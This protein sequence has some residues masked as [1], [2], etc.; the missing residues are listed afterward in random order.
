MPVK[1]KRHINH[2][3][4]FIGFTRTDSLEVHMRLHENK[5]PILPTLETLDNI[6]EHYIEVD[7]YSGRSESEHSDN[8]GFSDQDDGLP[9]LEEETPG[10]DCFEPQVDIVES[11]QEQSERE[12]TP[13]IK[14]EEF[15]EYEDDGDRDNDSDSAH[16]EYLPNRA[17]PKKGKRGRPRKNKTQT[18][19]ER[20]ESRR[21]RRAIKTEVK[22]SYKYN[23][24]YVFFS[25][26][27]TLRQCK[28]N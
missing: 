13:E 5:A 27:V 24:Y 28:E 22:V 12:P 9:E 26:I 16:S 23:F 25:N 19:V 7:D 17:K 10:G 11:A 8:D 15:V 1:H 6:H 2:N 21:Q 3:R 20:R 18:K 4:I 14:T